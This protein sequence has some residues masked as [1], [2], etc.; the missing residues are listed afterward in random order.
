MKKSLWVDTQICAVLKKSIT[1]QMRG[2]FL[3][4]SCPCSIKLLNL[5]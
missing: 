5:S 3:E 4:R 2:L 1:G